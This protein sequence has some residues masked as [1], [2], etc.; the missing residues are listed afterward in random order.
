MEYAIVRGGSMK[1][2]TDEV[3]RLL[4]QG[5]MIA[6]GVAVR[7]YREADPDYIQAMTHVDSVLVA[8]PAR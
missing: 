8:A 1:G 4:A 7:Q 5:W 2:L 6:G 3:N